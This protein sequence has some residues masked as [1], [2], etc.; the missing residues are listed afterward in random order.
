MINTALHNAERKMHTSSDVLK[1]DLATIRTGH[2]TP[3]LIEHIKVEY[4]GIPTSLNQIA[5]ITAPEISILIIQP[6]DRSSIH[7]IEK[8]I[9]KS[10]LGLTP[11]NDGSI[12]R[13]N[14]PPL[15]E[16]RRQELIRVVHNRV[17]GR[18]IAIRSI[19]HEAINEF[20]KFAK[21]KHISEDE[22]KRA[23]E[24]L[25]QLTEKFIAD[26]ELIGQEKEIELA[27]I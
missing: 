27:E 8:A 22:H 20:K 5:R 18:R 14:I 25:Q 23:L 11:S 15:T 10:E 7:N 9:L 19:R 1:S 17:E 12:I 21:N 3:A 24:Q 13:L 16:E 26:I 4:S 6:W 2:A